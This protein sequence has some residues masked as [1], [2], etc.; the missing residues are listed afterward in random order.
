[1][2]D[3]HLARPKTPELHAPF[4]IIEPGIDLGFKIGSRNDDAIFAFEAGCGGFS[5]LHRHYSS[6]PNGPK[7]IAFLAN[8]AKFWSRQVL[9]KPPELVRAEG[10]EPPRLSSRDSKSRASTNSATPATRRAARR[11]YIT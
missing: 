3:R 2:S 5:Y 1:M 9:E 7:Y 8:L 4:E 11:A 6:R 10:L